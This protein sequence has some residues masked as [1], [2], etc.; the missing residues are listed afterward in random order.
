[1]SASVSQ[2]NNGVVIHPTAHV[3][4]GAELGEGV[5]IGPFCH[6]TQKVVL[7]DRV[8]LKSHAVVCNDTHIG[9]DSVV[10]S[11]AVVGSEPQNIA[12]KGE[13]TILRVG[14]RVTIR[15]GV[16]MNIGTGNSLG[17]TVVGND[18]MFLAYAHVAHDCVLGNNVLF[19]NNVMIGG[20]TTI[21]DHVIVGGG[22]GIHQFCTVGHHAFIG[23][24]TAVVSDVIPYGMVV[25]SRGYLSGL[26][27]V[28]M[29]RTG[30]S[31][32][33]INAVRNGYKAL[34]VEN[35]KTMR[36]NAHG[37][38][39]TFKDSAPVVEMANFVLRDTKR[40]FMT[41]LSGGRGRGQSSD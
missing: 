24:V 25:G 16:T 22:A 32:D 10:F 11:H 21:G 41:P 40:K 26:N 3:E 15:E 36:E 2:A 29:K 14:K 7:G 33:D 17:K 4:D 23:G 28:G 30:M 9:D 31:R 34:F 13:D 8:E 6:V 1:M 35:G 19:A 20:H 38:L 39:E 12:Y 27:L 5:K 37:L 18:C